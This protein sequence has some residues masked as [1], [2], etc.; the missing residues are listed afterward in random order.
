MKKRDKKDKKDKKNKDIK[1]INVKALF[2]LNKND[3]KYFIEKDGN[4]RKFS[5]DIGQQYMLLLCMLSGKTYF[6]QIV[7]V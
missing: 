1:R 6:V 7:F 4:L 5:K 3:C 2:K